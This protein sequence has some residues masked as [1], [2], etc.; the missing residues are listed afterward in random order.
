M[1]RMGPPL[2]MAVLLASSSCGNVAPNM[3]AGNVDLCP[4]MDCDDSDPCTMDTCLANTCVH[5]TVAIHGEKMFTAT[6]TIETFTLD[7]CVRI[8]T[9]EAAGAR[10]GNSALN[11]QAGGPGAHLKGDF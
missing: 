3:D 7:A 11:K 9:I 6:D 2:R 10:G 1:F 4:A 8:I 5:N